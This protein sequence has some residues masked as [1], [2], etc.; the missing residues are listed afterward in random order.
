VWRPAGGRGAADA[1]GVA[2]VV[3]DSEGDAVELAA[4]LEGARTSLPGGARVERRGDAIV[5]L[6]GAPTGS[7]DGIARH[8]WRTFGRR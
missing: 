4:A 3:M 6:V 5:L 2:Y 7:V 8:V 1:V